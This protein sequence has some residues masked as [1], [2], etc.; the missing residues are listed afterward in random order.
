MSTGKTNPMSRMKGERGK[1]RMGMIFPKKI[2]VSTEV[3]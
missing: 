1:D 2:D 3:A